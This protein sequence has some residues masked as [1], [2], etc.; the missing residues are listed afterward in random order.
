MSIDEI[1]QE[2]SKCESPCEGATCCNTVVPVPEVVTAANYQHL[3]ARTECDQTLAFG[4]IVDAMEDP[5][6]P[7]NMT[8]RLIH[9]CF[10]LTSDYYELLHASSRTNLK[11]ELGDMLWYLAEAANAKGW[12]FAD[13]VVTPYGVFGHHYSMDAIALGISGMAEYLERTYFYRQPTPD[14]KLE[15]ALMNVYCG[16]AGLCNVYGFTVEQVM[17]ANIAKLRARFPKKFEYADALEEARDR[18]QEARVV[19]ASN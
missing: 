18:V 3:A 12:S 19:E 7:A 8:V 15:T 9:A 1:N 2:L 17:S 13:R 6:N 11:E 10:G 5:T 16:I 4:A 14:T